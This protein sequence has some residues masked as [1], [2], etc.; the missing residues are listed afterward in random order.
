M[1]A[2]LKD[3]TTRALFQSVGSFAVNSEHRNSTM[4][5]WAII[6][7]YRRRNTLGMLSGPQDDFVFKFKIIETTP[8]Y[9][10]KSTSVGWNTLGWDVVRLVLAKTLW[11]KVLKCSAMTFRSVTLL[12]LTKIC[13]TCLLPSLRKFQNL[14]GSF[15]RKF[16]RVVL[17]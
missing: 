15:F 13:D 3:G 9:D 1:V 16:G 4:T 12:P 11:K 7:A 8:E 17:K 2:F 5:K 14:L 10:M 6:S